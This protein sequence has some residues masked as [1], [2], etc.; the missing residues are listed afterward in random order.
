M[1]C[2]SASPQQGG[3]EPS[4]PNG[5]SLSNGHVSGNG[6]V[7]MPKEGLPSPLVIKSPGKIDA[8]VKLA[9]TYMEDQGL[10]LDQVLPSH[11]GL[12]HTRWA[13]HGPPSAKNSHPH[14]SGP[15]NEFVVVHNGI[16][17]NHKALKD[18]LVRCFRYTAVS[19]F[20]FVQFSELADTRAS[21][22][23]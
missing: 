20:W 21:L 3:V 17:T 18:F 9:N 6:H 13:T 15:E 23:S 14:V 19:T 10:D 8:L 22:C 7:R 12:A 1:P 16:I 11:A 5:A 2:V 4:L